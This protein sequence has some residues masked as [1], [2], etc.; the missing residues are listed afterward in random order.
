MPRLDRINRRLLE[1]LQRDGRMSLTELARHVGRS[2]TTVRDRLA[3]L[4]S[5]G[6]LQG[7]Q[8]LV[9]ENALGFRV[10]AFVRGSCKWEDIPQVQERLRAVPQVMGVSLTG[11][12]RPILMEVLVQDLEELVPL[13]QQRIAPAGLEDL[14]V[15]PVLQTLVRHRP[16]PVGDRIPS[17]EGEATTNLVRGRGRTSLPPALWAPQNG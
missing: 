11:G 16:V 9:D 8:A 3:S 2:E 7:Y 10:R 1:L 15:E 17:R 5:A 14:E 13:L 4:Q 6:I 12:G